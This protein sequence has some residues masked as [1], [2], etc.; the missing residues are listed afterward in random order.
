MGILCAGFKR[1]NADEPGSGGGSELKSFFDCAYR[2]N[3]LDDVLLW[4]LT[5]SQEAKEAAFGVG[6]KSVAKT[7]EE[8]WSTLA[9]K[10][11]KL[12]ADLGTVVTSKKTV[13]KAKAKDKAKDNEKKE[14]PKPKPVEEKKEKPKEDDEAAKAAAAKAAADAE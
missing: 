10:Y 12:G 9:L 3:V 6:G 7:H 2:R 4:T 13:P 8:L 14:K 11:K 1:E 5:A